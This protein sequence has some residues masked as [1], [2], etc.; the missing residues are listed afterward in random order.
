MKRACLWLAL[1]P[2]LASPATFPQQTRQFWSVGDGLPA[3]DVLAV[4][5]AGVDVYAG[6][7][8]G[9]ARFSGG[10]WSA[11][12]G[13][14]G[15]VQLVAAH[16]DECF[17]ASGGALYRVRR[18]GVEKVAALP[19]GT[20]ALAVSLS[21]LAV[22]DGGI[23][24][25]GNAGF[26]RQPGPRG[27]RHAAV[28]PRGELAVA[29][30]EGLYLR[31]APGAPWQSLFPREGNRR[32]APEDVRAVAY[33]AR[34]RMWFASPQGVGCLDGQW[35]LYTGDEGLP[36]DDFTSIAAAP[37]GSVWFGT[38]RG[39]I[40]FHD[41]TWE[42][43]Q[44]LRWLPA[45]NVRAVAVSPGGQ[46][47][48][49]TPA[50]AGSI[51]PEPMTFARKAAYLEEQIDQYHR[52]TPYGYVDA[53]TVRGP[54]DPAGSTQHDSDNDGL[55]TAMYGAGECFAWAATRDPAA[56]RRA[57]AA[58]EALRFLHTVTQGGTPPA[59]P[60]FVARTIL[61]VSGPDPN[62]QYTREKDEQ[63]RAKR[64]PY[65]KVMHPR[66]PKSADGL[67]YWKADTSSDE[68]DGHYFFHAL[69]YDLVA[70]TEDEKQEVRTVVSAITDHL[71]KH[72]FALVDWDGQPT[73]WAVFGPGELNQNPRWIVE[74]G[75]NSLSVLAYLKVAE[76]ITG[77]A[78]YGQA[79]RGL[80]E[81]HGYAAN[82]MI[83]KLSTG[84]GSGNQSDDEMAFMAY[85]NL[86]RYESDPKLRQ[87]Y[88]QSLGNYWLT[89]K[90]ELNPLFNFIHAA[91]T[92]ST[93][94]GWLEESLDTLRRY[95]LDRF[96]WRLSNSHRKD[97]VPLAEH[98]RDDRRYPAGVRRNG[99]VLPADERFIDHWN[100]DPFRLDQG[101]EGRQLADGASF[102]LPY[103]MGLYH[104]YVPD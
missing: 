22:G 87:M 2:L 81:R 97:I 74:R 4:A 14:T 94:G 70:G 75:L 60:G 30:A 83:A 73:R 8:Q 57:R 26:S 40:R 82:A 13:I 20:R 65:W 56:K 64:D 50:G 86:I 19:T 62:L 96:D 71:I 59:R 99:L 39:A 42:Y 1:V 32:W 85:Y 6:T 10:K 48:F 35:R 12:T 53:V 43:R 17:A 23:F 45:D 31:R 38:A 25:L 79:Y 44:G 102:L 93:S 61:P 80:I 91:S 54:G 67:W 36:Y 100:Q 55:W 46:A 15:P 84:P 78:R 11:I 34:G 28:G 76:H 27:L 72:D 18:S 5:A 33:D 92:G 24:A 95:P 58:F 98:A 66:W 51:T 101:G 21:V 9:L 29:G 90:P 52:R 47:W 3:S 103:Y 89:E 16:G 77:E 68:L 7:S 63:F 69:Y 49:A 41:G 37:D 88:V 104:R